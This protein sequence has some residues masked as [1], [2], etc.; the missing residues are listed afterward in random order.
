MSLRQEE[1]REGPWGWPALQLCAAVLRAQGPLFPSVD[2]ATCLE[3]IL[4]SL[5]SPHASFSEELQARGRSRVDAEIGECM[6]GDA[7][8]LLCMRV[9]QHDEG[10]GV[11]CVCLVEGLHPFSQI[12]LED[13]LLMLFLKSVL[14]FSPISS[15]RDP[16]EGDW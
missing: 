11:V 1:Q 13:D 15:C 4:M 10:V 2:I 3:Q 5:P 6:Q 7:P 16:E 14:L 9:F 12:L 8:V